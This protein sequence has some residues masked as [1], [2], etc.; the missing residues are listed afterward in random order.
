MFEIGSSLRQARQHRGL[1]LADVER[2]TRIRVKYL[3]ALEDER[4]DVLPGVAYVR[5]FLRTYSE[6]LGLDG[7]L[8]I[9]RYNEVFAPPEDELPPIQHQGLGRRGRGIGQ[10]LLGTLAALAGGTAIVW[11]LGFASPQR[12]AIA[13]PPVVVPR[14]VTHVT[15]LQKVRPHPRPSVQ[16]PRNLV[17]RAARGDCWIAVRVGSATGP[18]LYRRILAHGG[19][20]RFPLSKQRLWVRLGAPWNADVVVRGKRVG[21]LPRRPV[22]LRL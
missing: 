13:Q 22:N 3:A 17:V 14:L 11:Q 18:V 16:A 2:E 21:G 6:F 12:T 1:E 7:N 4:F 5:G 19:T 15:A 9:D 20:V 8:Y 10:P